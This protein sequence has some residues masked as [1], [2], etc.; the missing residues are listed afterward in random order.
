MKLAGWGHLP[1]IQ[2]QVLPLLR[3]SDLT[4][5]LLP[6]PGNELIAHGLGR[7]YGDS[8]LASR[9]ISTPTLDHFIHFDEKQGLLTCAAGTSLAEILRVMVPQGWFLMVT[10][11]TQYVTVAGAVA[12]DVHG[13][14]HTVEGTFC[15]HVT[16]LR[17]ATISHGVVDCSPQQ[18]PDLF[19]ATCGGMGLTGLILEV[20]FKLKRITSAYIDQTTIKTR[21][22]QE[23]FELFEEHHD[24][25]YSVAW[26]DCLASGKSLGR[27][28]L[29]LG[30]H[31]VDGPLSTPAGPKLNVP[32]HMPGFILNGLTMAAFNGLYYHHVRR[33]ISKRRGHYAPFFYP[34]DNITNW[35]RLYGVNGFMQYQFVLPTQAGLAGMKTM[36]ERITRSRQGS[37]LAV[38]KNMGPASKG[39]LSFPLP[40]Y[41][42]ALDFKMNARLP[43][44]LDELD[45]VVLDYQG[46]LYLAKDARMSQAVFRAGYPQ[47]EAFMQIRQKYQAHRVFHSLQSR[48]IGLSPQEAS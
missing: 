19:Y 1:I 9:V 26:I 34:L 16:Q 21:N 20:T 37:F 41:S 33:E 40:G 24:C 10:P 3:E 43:A 29:M 27:S 6:A 18:H 5:M 13:K 32:C 35:N 39:L 38:L 42:L 8:A 4:Q 7:S 47:W 31:A 46:R 15:N 30:Q 14:N 28:L 48:R 17:I 25:P 23:L 2:S 44:L 22:L 11:G 45:R 12:S 36:L